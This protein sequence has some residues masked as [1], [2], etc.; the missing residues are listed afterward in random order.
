M[1]TSTTSGVWELDD[2]Y[3][4][5]NAERWRPGQESYELYVSGY[6]ASGNI[7]INDALPRSSPVQIPGTQWSQYRGTY[8]G[9]RALKTDGTLW[10]WGYNA[11]GGLGQ[12]DT[13]GYS[14]PIQVPGTQWS[15]IA[16]SLE[17]I[18]NTFATKTDGTLWAWGDNGYGELGQNNLTKYSSP[19][20]VPGTQWDGS[21]L[22]VGGYSV[23]CKKTDGT[24]WAWG[25]NNNGQLGLNERTLYSSPVQVPGTQWG[26]VLASAFGTS[27]MSTKTD[28][29]LWVWG[30]NNH[31]RLGLNNLT[32][33]S[34]PVQLPGTQW[35]SSIF[36]FSAGS[37]QSMG[38]K[39]DG[40]L[41]A[42][43]RNG[44]GSLGQNNR[45]YYSSPVQI[46]GT[47]WSK[48]ELG[49][50]QHVFALKT[51]E[52]LWVWGADNYGQLGQNNTIPRSSPVQI[53]G[54][55]WYDISSGSYHAGAIKQILSY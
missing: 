44:F 32:N 19:I 42:F 7:G 6:N 14:S 49:Y 28:G 55:G 48:V 46:P 34:S 23:H 26:I 11:Y 53:P 27:T 25:N 51:D 12:N 37:F 22:T 45:T 16:T 15:Y 52:T 39:T 13:I 36:A 31:G 54:T 29:T 47:Q 43:G 35:R 30:L 2:T 1:I 50:S 41:W 20:Q 5:I 9:S 10:A 8:A 21:I 4:K 17:T 3:A 33:Y 38:T 24:L 40:T 18:N